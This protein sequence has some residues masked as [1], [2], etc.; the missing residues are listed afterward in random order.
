MFRLNH[1]AVRLLSGAMGFLLV[2]FTNIASAQAY[3]NRP[4]RF[5]VP[6]AAGGPTDVPARIVA[7]ALGNMLGQRFIVENRLGAGGMLSGEAVARAEPNGY[8]LLYGNSSVLSINPA[9]FP[10]MPYDTAT[11]FTMVGFV[12]DSPQLLITHPKFPAKN[13]RELLDYSKANPGK[14]NFAVAGSG[15]LPHLTYELFKLTTGL[16]SLAVPYNGGAPAL[17]AVV[18]GQAD[19][20]F[21]LIR[22]RVMSGELRALAITASTRDPDLPDVQTIAEAGFPEVVSTSWTGVAAPA[23]T[24]REV[25]LFLNSKLNELNKSPE[26]R[27]KMKAMGLV[28]R[29]GTPEEFNGWAVAQRLKWAQVVKASGAKPN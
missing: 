6:G 1:G 21:D 7:D 23:G 10:K 9:L 12:S 4:V 18:T 19:L 14:I 2:V 28:P 16:D 25:I 5:M 17:Q 20:L 15:T 3:P 22:T 24:P 11:A 29:A 26:F 13:V 27:A 8:T